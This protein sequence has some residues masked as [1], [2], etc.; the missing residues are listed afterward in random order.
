MLAERFGACKGQT[1]RWSRLERG[2]ERNKPT[3]LWVLQRLDKTF[4]LTRSRL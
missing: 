4:G 2:I 3:A 1:D